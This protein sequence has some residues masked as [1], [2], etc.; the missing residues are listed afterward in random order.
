[1]ALATAAHSSSTV[2]AVPFRRSALSLEGVLD[3]IEVGRVGRP[4]QELR[5]GRLDRLAHGGNLVGG[6]VVQ[7]HHIAGLQGGCEHLLGHCQGK[8]TEAG[9]ASTRPFRGSSQCELKAEQELRRRPGIPN[10]CAT[11]NKGWNQGVGTFPLTAPP[12]AFALT[13]PAYPLAAVDYRPVHLG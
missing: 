10:T 1:M 12:G 13:E 2:R 7:D 4:E 11:V 3:W 5:A 6:Q 9:F 8:Y